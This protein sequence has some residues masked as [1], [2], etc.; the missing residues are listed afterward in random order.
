MQALMS[1]SRS[2]PG[3]GNR[4]LRSQQGKCPPV[5][6]TP[7]LRRGTSAG[8]MEPS[9]VGAVPPLPR[10]RGPGAGSPVPSSP[11][12]IPSSS[13]TAQGGDPSFNTVAGFCV[14]FSKQLVCDLPRG[15]YRQ[16]PW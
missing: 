16:A 2:E 5:P 14:I 9:K 4:V 6:A 3:L 12:F 15:L 7:A 10:L 13:P 11:F 8:R 1:T